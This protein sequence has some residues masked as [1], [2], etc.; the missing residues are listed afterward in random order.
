M[1]IRT[2]LKIVGLLMCTNPSLASNNQI[3]YTR[4]MYNYVDQ[5]L[6]DIRNSDLLEK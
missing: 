4:N 6:L 5:G 3:V 2:S 1:S